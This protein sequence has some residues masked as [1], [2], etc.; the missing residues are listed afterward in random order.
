M[1]AREM[2]SRVR[3]GQS[4]RLQRVCLSTTLTSQINVL[5]WSTRRVDFVD[6]LAFELYVKE[7]PLRSRRRRLRWDTRQIDGVCEHQVCKIL[8]EMVGSN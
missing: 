6:G 4:A 2:L 1:I 7:R 5:C 3:H 8:E